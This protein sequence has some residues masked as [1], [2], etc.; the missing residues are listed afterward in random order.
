[1]KKVAVLLGFAAALTFAVA[2]EAPRPLHPAP[3]RPKMACTDTLRAQMELDNV[4]TF[5]LKSTAYSDGLVQGA[6]LG[7]GGALLVVALAFRAKK[8]QP[9]DRSSPKPLSHAASA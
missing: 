2:A 5:R 1:M 6:G 3:P 4:T 9:G 7:A 8:V